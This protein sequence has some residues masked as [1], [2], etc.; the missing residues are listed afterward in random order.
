[1]GLVFDMVLNVRSSTTSISRATTLRSDA[2]VLNCVALPAPYVE[3]SWSSTTRR[4][5]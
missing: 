3:S 4:Q 2:I 5:L 1:M